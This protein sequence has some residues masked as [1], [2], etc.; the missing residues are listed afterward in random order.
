MI[1]RRDF[2]TSAV[3]LACTA[4]TGRSLAVGQD[5]VPGSGA[6]REVP[7]LLPKRDYRSKPFRIAVA[8]GDSI[9]E[10]WT[11]T[12][13][14]LCWVNRLA[15]SVNES[16]L[17]PMK[18]VNSGSGG[19]VVSP[20]S[21]GYGQFGKPSA[22]ERYQKHVVEHRP[23]L[24]TVAYGVNDA[25]AGTPVGQFAQ[26][27]RKIVLDIKSK[28]GALI[29]MVSTSYMTDFERYPPFDRGSIAVF[30]AYNAAI[31]WLSGEC[32]VL[33]ADVFSALSSARWTVDPEDGV[34]P[35]NLGH[36]LIADCV[37]AG[38]AGNCTCLSQKALEMRKNFKPWQDESA[39]PMISK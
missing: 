37:F 31:R 15:D 14:E 2:L 34:H 38:L 11:A 33:Y 39:L 36:K 29:V 3:G 24:V 22:L 30:E 25:R 9:T 32:D 19:D 18:M 26:D 13:P 4:L 5:S 28:T 17:V 6:D 8:F 1:A 27:L 12:S 10:G 23:D 20:R 16:Q 7:N 35:N 21:A